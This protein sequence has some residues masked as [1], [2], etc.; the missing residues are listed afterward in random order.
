MAKLQFNDFANRISAAL[1]SYKKDEAIR[2]CK[3]LVA[4]LNK[5]GIKFTENE[6]ISLLELLRSHRYFELMRDVSDALMRTGM[7]NPTV[8]RHHAQALIEIEDFGS[9]KNLLDSM[10]SSL[11]P[12]HPE[13]IEAQGLLGRLHKQRYVNASSDLQNAFAH[14]WSVFDSDR[15]Q[16]WH[17]AN[18]LALAKLA[19]RDKVRLPIAVDVNTIAQEARSAI[20]KLSNPDHW[21]LA[22]SAEA[23]LA[24][25]NIKTAK[26]DYLRFTKHA[27]VD[28][29]AITSAL[30]QLNEVWR[31]SDESKSERDLIQL[32]SSK[33]LFL[34]G[35]EVELSSDQI[36]KQLEI[37]QVEY[38]KIYGSAATVTLDWYLKGLSRC[39]NIA[40]I[41]RDPT[42]G[43]GTGFLIKGE[44][45]HPK[46]KGKTVLVTNAHVISDDPTDEATPFLEAVAFFER[47]SGTESRFTEILW[48]S[49][50]TELDITVLALEEELVINSDFPI[51]RSMP[52]NSP[53]S[54]IYVIGHPGGGTLAFSLQDNELVS[55]NDSHLWYRTPTEGGSSGS[56]IFNSQWELIG[57]HHKGGASV[58][59][60]SKSEVTNANEGMQWIAVQNSILKNIV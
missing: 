47:R 15:S 1:A 19:E 4:A 29:F 16:Y 40:R 24:A 39:E 54:R 55:Y 7:K 59:A 35:G 23:A 49:K 43:I 38:Q 51:A 31:I 14:Y 17:A 8:Q 50:K 44:K 36:R 9:A 26:K 30:R 10:V 53:E 18:V 11:P 20:K 37:N 5:A 25:G 45:L 60:T 46:W 27:N 12:G 3:E 22:T 32:L 52:L 48:H 58:I 33:L 57:V 42:R 28:A 34:R 21:A 56:P 13:S 6:A 2:A 41:G